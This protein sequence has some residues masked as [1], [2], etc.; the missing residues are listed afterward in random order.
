MAPAGS[1]GRGSAIPP[2]LDAKQLWELVSRGRLK[3]AETC[4][5]PRMS[6]RRKAILLAGGSVQYNEF[7]KKWI[8]IAGQ[9]H[10]SASELGE[11]WYSEAEHPEGPWLLAQKS[12]RTIIIRFIIPCI[13]AFFDQ[14]GGRIIYF[15]GTYSNTFSGNDHPTPLYDYNQ[16]MYR[17]DLSD[18]RLALPGM[19]MKQRRAKSGK[20]LRHLRKYSL[21]RYEL[22]E[23]RF[24]GKA[25]GADPLGLDADFVRSAL[26]QFERPLV[27]YASTFWAATPS[28]R[29][30]VVQE[31]FFRL[32]AGR[33]NGASRTCR[34]WLYAVCRNMAIDIR[35]KEQ[36]MQPMTDAL[37]RKLFQRRRRTDGGCRARLSAT[38]QRRCEA[39]RPTSRKSSGSSSSTAC[40]TSKSA[41]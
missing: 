21:V 38:L 35:R 24:C 6:R 33:A 25:H 36:R 18:P 2:A 22:G 40:R 10:G 4:F 39:S 29:T 19:K 17:L 7:R 27:G 23:R 31:A 20:N 15:E 16:M 3:A 41:R 32:C 14:Q 1:S 37:V 11:I 9:L 30:D 34:E 12:S 28:G 5:R 13:D 26:R 8:M